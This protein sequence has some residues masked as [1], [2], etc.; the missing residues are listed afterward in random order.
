MRPRGE[1]YRRNVEM[2]PRAPLADQP[3]DSRSHVISIGGSSDVTVAPEL[4]RCVRDLMLSGKSTI[5][6]DLTQAEEL[7]PSLLGAL[8]RAQ[9]SLSWR[10]GRLLLVSEV[11]QVRQQLAAVGL[12]DLLD[13][14]EL[15]R[16]A[17]A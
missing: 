1:P 4:E 14:D 7:T 10:N 8:I 17:G 12:R 13:L 16:L 2:T 3:I 6:A 11:P 5:V 9:R 15:R